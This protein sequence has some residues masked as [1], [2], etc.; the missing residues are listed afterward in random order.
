MPVSPVPVLYI[1]APANAQTTFAEQEHS[2]VALKQE[3]SKPAARSRLQI[4]FAATHPNHV[5]QQPCPLV[6]WSSQARGGRR[7]LD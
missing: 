5:R 6:C 1:R 4:F 2:V 3:R 7:S